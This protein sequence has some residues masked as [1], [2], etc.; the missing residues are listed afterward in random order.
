MM[1][2]YLGWMQHGRPRPEDEHEVARYW[3]QGPRRRRNQKVRDRDSGL[4]RVGLG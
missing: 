1:S 3:L 2:H 4:A